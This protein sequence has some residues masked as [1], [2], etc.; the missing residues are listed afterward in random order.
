MDKEQT[1]E[2][3]DRDVMLARLDERTKGLDTRLTRVETKVDALDEKIDRS[4]LALDEKID[5]LEARFDG[6][7]NRLY[8]GGVVLLGASIG[9]VIA[10]ALGA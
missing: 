1:H 5:A 4:F 7:F 6:K 2:P 3:E 9:P 10:K 8:A